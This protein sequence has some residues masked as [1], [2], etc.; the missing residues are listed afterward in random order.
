MEYGMKS[1]S[2]NINICTILQKNECNSLAYEPQLF[3]INKY[4]VI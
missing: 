2:K 4:I 3:I 1:E